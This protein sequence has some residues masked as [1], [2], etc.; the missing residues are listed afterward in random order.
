MYARPVFLA[1]PISQAQRYFVTVPN[2][3]GKSL[4]SD[5]GSDMICKIQSCPLI[6]RLLRSSKSLRNDPAQ[7]GYVNISG[8]IGCSVIIP[9][10]MIYEQ[11]AISH[12][13]RSKKQAKFTEII[14][15]QVA[16][17]EE[18]GLTD[19]QTVFS[20]ALHI[21]ML[22][23][24]VMALLLLQGITDDKWTNRTAA[25]MIATVIYE[26]AGDLQHIFGRPFRDACSALGIFQ[27][28][29]CD[30][31]RV[32]KELAAFQDSHEPVLKPIRMAAGAHRDHDIVKFLGAFIDESKT[33]AVV[34]AAVELEKCLQ[35]W[36]S[37]CTEV[38]D[39]T[40]EAVKPSLPQ[41]TDTEQG[42]TSNGG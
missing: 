14:L 6:Q 7:G 3:P 19:A 26:G 31:A 37:F 32:K 16:T 18:S 13:A 5:V 34:D 2:K 30:L 17:F 23:H 21:N 42:S 33:I 25:R 41:S 12:L 27:A 36:G 8:E 4:A 29:E 39:L 40:R 9:K 38:M 20:A 28:I 10:E 24:D 22:S 35:N 11:L 1:T 15:D